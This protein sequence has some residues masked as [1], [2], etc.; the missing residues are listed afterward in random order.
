MDNMTLGSDELKR[1][2]ERMRFRL[3]Q[4]WDKLRKEFTKRAERN[5]KG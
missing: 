3:D 1:A 5:R 4:R 2:I